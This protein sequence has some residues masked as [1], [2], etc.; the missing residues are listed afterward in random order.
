MGDTNTKEEIISGWQV[1]TLDDPSAKVQEQQL[2]VLV[3][4]LSWT[5]GHVDYLLNE[6]QDSAFDAN[7]GMDYTT[8]TEAVFKR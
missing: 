2:R 6:Q 5:D 3:N 1:I 7:D 8:W 4:D